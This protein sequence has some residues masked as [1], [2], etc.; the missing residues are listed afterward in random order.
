[1]LF[2]EPLTS[3]YSSFD[4]DNGLCVPHIDFRRVLNYLLKMLF[5]SEDRDDMITYVLTQLEESF[6]FFYQMNIRI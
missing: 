2:R 4:I 3:G 5:S 6:V 1:M